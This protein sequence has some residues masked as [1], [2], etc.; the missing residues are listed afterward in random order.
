MR[1]YK[2]P[3]WA[4]VAVAMAFA[5]AACGSSGSSSSSSSAAAGSSSSTSTSSGGTSSGGSGGTATVVVGTFPQSLDPSIDFTTQGGEVHWLTY[6]GPYSFAHATGTA[7]TQIIP[8]VAT[9]LP[10]A[11]DGGKTYTFT[12]RTNL[13]YSD[14]TPLKASDLTFGIERALKLGW[15]AASFLTSTIVGAAD[16]AKG[17]AKAV[18]GITTDDATGKTTI[19][20]VNPYG[21]FVDVLAV[22]G[23]SYM[24]ATTP[25]KPEPNNP[26]IG[27]GPYII[28]NV[29]NN[30]GFDMV[31][32]PNYAAQAIPGIPPGHMDIHVKIESNTTT[33]AQDV[34]NN[35][36]DVFDWGDTIPPAQIQQVSGLTD[37]YKSLATSKTFY[38]FLN[39]TNKPFNNALARQ[40]VDV[41]VDRPALARL[42]S[43]SIIPGCFLLPPAMVGHPTGPCPAGN[44]A[45]SPDVAKA[46]QM[47]QQSGMAGQPVTVW[48]QNRQPRLEYAENYAATLN[49]IGFKATLKTIADADYFSTIETLKNH[50]QT[51][52]ADWQQDFPN[53]TDFYQNLVDANAIVPVGNSNYEEV[54]DP[55]IQSELK[56][57]Y[58]V[59]ANQLGTVGSRWAAL[60]S[61]VTSKAYLVS[62]GYQSSP[63]FV[64]N[65]IDFSKLVFSPLEG[66]DFST[67]QTK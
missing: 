63:E 10:V 36:A 19:H 44:P 8:S 62:Y 57:L 32:N 47:V 18:S 6:L 54:N 67:L 35:T 15:S 61:Y 53:P 28:K 51:G 7:G 20:L 5:V 24:P 22:P 48:A 30:V 2:R 26:P 64:S 55:H 41:A 11:S 9:A 31:R 58:P 40:A 1:K 33:E 21:A 13:K 59:P 39:T 12:I 3:L 42:S 25:M 49:A 65:R 17:K 50:P 56:A 45:S 46:K 23:V 4:A 38:W 37:R 27:F 66:N 14:G 34:I 16:Y 60:D 29:Q 52:F 43:G